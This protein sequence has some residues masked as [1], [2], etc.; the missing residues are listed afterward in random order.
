MYAPLRAMCFE[1]EHIHKK[2]QTIF[3]TVDKK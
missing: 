1:V 2:P 3:K